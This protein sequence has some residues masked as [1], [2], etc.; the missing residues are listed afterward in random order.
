MTKP[1]L[2][3]TLEDVVPGNVKRAMA[4]AGAKSSDLWKADPRLIKRREGF[5]VRIMDDELKAHIRRIADSI[6]T[7]G[8]DQSKPLSVF[9]VKEHGVDVPYLS[10]GHN[11][12]DAVMLAISEGAEIERVPLVV[13][14]KSPEE[15]TV[16]LVQSNSGKPLKPY[17]TAIVCKRLSGFGW[18]PAEIAGKLCFTEAYVTDLLLLINGPKKIRDLVIKGSLAANIAIEEMKKHGDKAVDRILEAM[19]RASQAG[20]S[21]VTRRFVAGA[22]FK[23]VL[24]KTAPTL[25]ETFGE[26]RSDPSYSSLSPGLREKLEAMLQTLDQAKSADGE[27]PADGEGAAAEGK[28]AKQAKE[29]AEA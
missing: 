10:D 2:N 4:E 15:L 29:P 5:N 17:E 27:P 7:N 25:Y 8:Y 14:T 26:L 12:H 1:N 28:A 16:A 11:R 6:K 19:E 18:E 3:E 9:V 23:K 22:S 21:K 13:E 20:K 24:T